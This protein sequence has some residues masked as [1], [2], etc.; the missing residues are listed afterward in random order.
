MKNINDTLLSLSLDVKNF[1]FDDKKVA[2]VQ[3]DLDAKKAKQENDIPINLIKENIEL[4]SSVL[5]RMFNF[6][7]DKISFP[8][9][10][11]QA[12]IT[13]VHKKDEKNDKNNYR[14]VSILPSLSK[15]FEKFLYDQIY[16]YTDSIE[17]KT[18]YAR[19]LG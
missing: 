8:N 6:Y 9:S 14:P 5:S 4:F 18:N 17:L 13:P 12:D 11:K 1:C 7:I 19:K 10:L 16:A 15:T 2:E 3:K